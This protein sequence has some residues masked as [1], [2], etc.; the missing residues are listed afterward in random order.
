MLARVKPYLKARLNQAQR[1]YANTFHAFSAADFLHALRAL[2]IKAGDTVLVHSSYDAFRG[3]TGKPTDVIAALQQAVGPDGNLLLPTLPFSGTA[4]AYARSN[5]IFDVKRTPSRTGLLTEL[6]R[7]LPA[8]TRSVHPTHAAAIWGRDAARLAD[9]HHLAETP[10]GEHSPYARLLDQQGKILMV[11]TDIASLTFYHTVEALLEKR[12]PVSPFTVESFSL[13][14]RDYSGTLLTTHTR[15]FE[16]AL[17]RRRNLYK[18]VPALKR[19]HAW[20]EGRVGL[21][22]LIALKA[23]NVLG[24]VSAMADG[25]EYCYD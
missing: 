7:R 18:L 3:F 4:V 8:V 1:L 16:P 21:V 17:S 22:G 14:S 23:E 6:F 12:F 13:Q 5:P 15:L 9:G 25:G 19:A 24:T 10:C 2:D 11:G 20:Q